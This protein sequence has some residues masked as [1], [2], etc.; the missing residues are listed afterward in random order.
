MQSGAITSKG[1][2]MRIN[3]FQI[4]LMG[5]LFMLL[6]G[7]AV[8]EEFDLRVDNSA[9]GF[10]GWSYLDTTALYGF[11]VDVVNHGDSS[12]AVDVRAIFTDFNEKIVCTKWKH[13]EEQISPNT[14]MRFEGTFHLPENAPERVKHV[15]RMLRLSSNEKW[16]FD[17]VEWAAWILWNEMKK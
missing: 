16:K 7:F 12:H 14:A 8:A 4:A 13:Y 15:S 11:W 1:L 6:A 3:T 10:V 5:M 17:P 9:I 2:T